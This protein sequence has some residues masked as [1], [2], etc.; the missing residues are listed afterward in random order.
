MEKSV[1]DSV[2]DDEYNVKKADVDG[3]VTHTLK[4]RLYKEHLDNF[5]TIK[6]F[7]VIGLASHL[8]HLDAI[9]ELIPENSKLRHTP[10]FTSNMIPDLK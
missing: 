7:L 2:P 4:S 3:Q 10:L 8:T 5:K 9:D 1:T 6:Q